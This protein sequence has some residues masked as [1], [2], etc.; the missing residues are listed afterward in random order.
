M[1][2]FAATPSMEIKNEGQSAEKE[3]NQTEY[4]L[5]LLMDTDF[6]SENQFM[7]LQSDC[8]ELIVM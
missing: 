5:S 8:K 6:I 4:W 7:S 2:Q 3:A 1:E